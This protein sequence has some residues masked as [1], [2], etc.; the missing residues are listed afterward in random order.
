MPPGGVDDLFDNTTPA[1]EA[2]RSDSI[3]DLFKETSEPKAAPEPAVPS[4]LDQDNKDNVDDLFSDP[5]PDKSTSNEP[6]AMRDWTDNTGKYHV[7]AR[8]VSV[9]ATSVRL[10]KENGRY[11]TVPFERLSQADLAFVR[12]QATGQI[13]SK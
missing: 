8:L 10:L 9:D 5:T 1:P 4:D 2:P 11:T 3:D 6:D 7:V 13:A 12:H